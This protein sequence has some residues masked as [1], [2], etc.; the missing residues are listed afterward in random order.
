MR[1]QALHLAS[2][3]GNKKMMQLLI[4]SGASVN[5]KDRWLGTPLSDALREGHTAVFKFLLTRSGSLGWDENRTS[6]ELCEL[7]LSIHG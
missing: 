1:V 4:D 7:A 2:S 6:S 5:C 3:E